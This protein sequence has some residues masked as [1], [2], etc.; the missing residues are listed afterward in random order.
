MGVGDGRLAWGQSERCTRAL[1]PTTRADRAGGKCAESSEIESSRAEMW[2]LVFG[3]DKTRNREA[4]LSHHV[5]KKSW[6][7]GIGGTVGP[8]R[9][10]AGR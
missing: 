2:P 3:R 10:T 6:K 4:E 1:S 7:V 8:R 9:P 5:K